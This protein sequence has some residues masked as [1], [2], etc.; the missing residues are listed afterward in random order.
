MK[1]LALPCLTKVPLPP[2]WPEN[3]L[4]PAD[5]VV[6][7]KPAICTIPAPASEPRVSLPPK[8]KVAELATLVIG[9]AVKRAALARVKL[10][11]VTVTVPAALWRLSWLAPPLVRL[12]VPRSRLTWPALRP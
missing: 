11:S 9:L 2:T 5:P 10:P 3:S 4:L 12:P 6:S 8:A 1:L 7:V